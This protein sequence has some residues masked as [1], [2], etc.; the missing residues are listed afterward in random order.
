MSD[1]AKEGK[2]NMNNHTHV[3]VC[4]KTIDGQLKAAVPADYAIEAVY[5]DGSVRVEGGDVWHVK[6]KDGL[7]VSTH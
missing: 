5:E 2:L 7:L 3:R 1:Q 6:E 4:H